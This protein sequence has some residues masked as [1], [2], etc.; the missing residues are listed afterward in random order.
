MIGTKF[1]SDA[2]C[3]FPSQ[4]ME[5]NISDKYQSLLSH[6]FEDMIKVPPNKKSKYCLKTG[7][8]RTTKANMM[9]KV[10]GPVEV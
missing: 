7:K 2:C 9:H 10:Q 4:N 1:Y 3:P 6:I 8:P 5:K